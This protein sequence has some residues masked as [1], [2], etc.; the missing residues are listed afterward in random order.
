MILI[1]FADEKAIW[2]CSSCTYTTDTDN[3]RKLMHTVER[4]NELIE[5][6]AIS[7]TEIILK[8]QAVKWVTKLI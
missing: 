2:K 7:G 4:E 8:E 5:K 3:V 6:T 1:Y